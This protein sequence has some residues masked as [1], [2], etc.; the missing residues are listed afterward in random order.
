MADWARE[1]E[2]HPGNSFAINVIQGDADGTL[3]W[4]FNLKLFQQKFPNMSLQLIHG[5]GHHMV[6]EREDLRQQIFSAIR[7]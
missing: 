7:L 4:Q 2:H 5:A 1:I 6:N 3:D